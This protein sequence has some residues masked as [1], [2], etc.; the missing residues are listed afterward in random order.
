MQQNGDALRCVSDELRGKNWQNLDEATKQS[1]KE[2]CLALQYPLLIQNRIM[3]PFRVPIWMINNGA[4]S[5]KSCTQRLTVALSSWEYSSSMIPS[6]Q[7]TK[8]WLVDSTLLKH[9]RH[10]GCVFQIR[11]KK[12]KNTCSNLFATRNQEPWKQIQPFQVS[13]TNIHGL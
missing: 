4:S 12:C 6:D 3:Y 7:K 11:R 10:F 13:S 2:I 1:A 5:I 8:T 9:I